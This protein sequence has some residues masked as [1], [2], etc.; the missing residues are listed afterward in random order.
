MHLVEIPD[1]DTT[2]LTNPANITAF[3]SMASIFASAYGT[4]SGSRV[5]GVLY[6]GM[7]GEGP[8]PQFLGLAF[9]KMVYS[10]FTGNPLMQM[11]SVGPLCSSNLD[12]RCPFR[13]NL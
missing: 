8:L 13:K 6:I 5:N 11:P 1:F 3:R 4:E 12:Q 7:I 2:D 9:G 10:S